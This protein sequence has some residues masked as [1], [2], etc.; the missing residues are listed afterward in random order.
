MRF[1]KIDRLLEEGKV[2][3]AIDLAHQVSGRD[4]KID[5]LGYIARKIGRNLEYEEYY[6]IIT[7]EMMEIAELLSEEWKKAKTFAL[8]GYIAHEAG[9]EL[10]AEKYFNLA[11]EHSSSIKEYIGRANALTEVA[12]YM[13]LSGRLNEALE[14]FKLAKEFLR[15]SQGNYVDPMMKLIRR[16]TEI[17]ERTTTP[18]AIKFYEL[19]HEIYSLLNMKVK[20]KRIENKIGLIK[21]AFKEGVAAVRKA[22][23]NGDIDSAIDVVKF[24]T[25]EDRLVALVEI[26]R[27]L[28]NNDQKKYAEMIAKDIASQIL[29]GDISVSDSSLS[30]IAYTLMNLGFLDEALITAGHISDE[31]ELS[32]ILADLSRMFIKLGNTRKALKIIKAIPH[33]GI[34]RSL[35]EEIQGELDVGHK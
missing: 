16:I 13:A 22:L 32:Q 9:K 20:A 26:A 24:L 23:E 28:Y 7:R 29:N 17:A 25:P 30:Y 34:R 4:S 27:W 11:L 3:E 15:N 21:S 10:E 1:E 18:D 31:V 14:I 12:Y 5:F 35:I 2:K 19:I 8:L 33:K 6:N